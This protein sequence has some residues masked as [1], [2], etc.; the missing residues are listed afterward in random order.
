VGVTVTLNIILA[1]TNPGSF[2]RGRNPA[3]TS[4]RLSGDRIPGRFT[5]A[6][7]IVKAILT[8][9]HVQLS[10]AEYAILLAFAAA[11]NLFALVASDFG[12]RSHGE[13]LTPT[14]PLENIPLVTMRRVG[15]ARKVLKLNQ[16]SAQAHAATFRSKPLCRSFDQPK[17]RVIG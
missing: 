4:G 8:E 15:S 7:T 14:R 9:S 12:F 10:L 13:T 17:N 1:T 2:C 16:P 5:A 11:F 3:R 6:F